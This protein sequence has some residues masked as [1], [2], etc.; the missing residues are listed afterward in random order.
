MTSKH[1]CPGGLTHVE[2]MP[3]VLQ[4]VQHNE[5]SETAENLWYVLKT[6]KKRLKYIWYFSANSVLE[7]NYGVWIELWIKLGYQ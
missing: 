1:Q 4:F 5:E 6:K 7:K 2:D 3:D